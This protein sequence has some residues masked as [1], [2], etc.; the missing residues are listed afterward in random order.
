MGPTQATPGKKSAGRLGVAAEKEWMLELLALNGHSLKFASDSIKADEDCVMTAV[1][2]HGCSLQFASG[3]LRGNRAIIEA[4]V[5]QNGVALK[6]AHRG[7]ESH[8]DC[9]KAAG[10]WDDSV[11]RSH[12]KAVFSCR[13]SLSEG[14]SEYASEFYLA[15]RNDAYLKRFCTYWPNAWARGSCDPDYTDLTHRCRGTPSTCDFTSLDKNMDVSTNRLRADCCWRFGFRYCLDT[16]R[17]ANGFM[18][19][20]EE[21]SGLAWGQKIEREMAYETDS[22]VFAIYTNEPAFN[23]AT[24][25]RVALAVEA[26]YKSGCLNRRVENV[27]LG[28][29]RGWKQQYD[30]VEWRPRFLDYRGSSSA[31]LFQGAKDV[32][33]RGTPAES[34]QA[35]PAPYSTA[36]FYDQC[37]A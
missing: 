4:A 31:A 3:Q 11:T 28:H 30:E 25:N 12:C 34:R 2:S 10:L 19:Q 9:L 15:M 14:S 8:P 6:F 36:A 33:S 26:W 18:I 17:A 20:L 7:L 27:F 32:E 22:K 35:A 29:G 23:L 16:A 13:Y 21:R 37:A 24:F 1:Q 5:K